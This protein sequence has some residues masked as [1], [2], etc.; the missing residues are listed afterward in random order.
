[1]LRL[2]RV[3]ITAL[4]LVAGAAS[5]W[6]AIRHVGGGEP[7]QPAARQNPSG[8]SVN[9]APQLAA[10]GSVSTRTGTN[11]QL[12]PRASDPDGDALTFSAANLPSWAHIDAATGTISGTPGASDLGENEAVTIT[13]ADATHQ[14][15]SAPFSITVVGPSAAVAVVK[16]SRPN[17]HVDGSALD[18]LA[19]YRI[20]YGRNPDDLDHSIFIANPD[21]LSY[22]FN[23]LDKG[24]WYFAVIAISSSGLEGPATTP[25]MKVI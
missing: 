21:Q 16:W 11:Y 3:S 2:Q 8:V 23:M 22:D 10:L 18:D 19:G 20:V 14:T 12:T 6:L 1:V 24:A 9:R 7:P 25:A 17:A 5:V 4:L 15:T 13:V